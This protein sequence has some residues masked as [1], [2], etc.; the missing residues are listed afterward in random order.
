[1][2]FGSVRSANDVG[3]YDDPDLHFLIRKGEIFMNF[4]IILFTAII[5]L[6]LFRLFFLVI[7]NIS[8]LLFKSSDDSLKKRNVLFSTT[9]LAV[10]IFSFVISVDSLIINI[11]LSDLEEYIIFSFIGIA[12]ITW[13]YLKWELSWKAMPKI[14]DDNTMVAIKKN[15]VFSMVMVVSFAY[16]Y[17]QVKKVISK[18]DVDEVLIVTNATIITGVIALDRVFNQIISLIKASEKKI[19]I[20]KLIHL[21]K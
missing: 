14:D 7:V 20:L 17:G 1:M 18:S 8:I 21:R 19:D 4:L 16:G 15:F 12:S 2:H 3:A 10:Y 9:F 11:V 5:V 13:C 6:I